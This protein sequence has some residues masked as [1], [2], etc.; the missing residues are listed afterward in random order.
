MSNE[1]LEKGLPLHL[2]AVWWIFWDFQTICEMHNDASQH[3]Y[4]AKSVLVAVN[5]IS[6]G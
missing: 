2:N 6:E 3:I 4:V 5:A 1:S